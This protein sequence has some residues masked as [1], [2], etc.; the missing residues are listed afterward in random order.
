MAREHHRLCGHEFEQTPGYSEGQRPG[1][2]QS[3][4]SQRVRQD[5]G[6][7]QQQ[8]FQDEKKNETHKLT[9]EDMANQ[10]FFGDLNPHLAAPKLLFV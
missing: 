5:L 9:Q 2:L 3:M 6:T 8:H 10:C 7:K 1:L 4:E